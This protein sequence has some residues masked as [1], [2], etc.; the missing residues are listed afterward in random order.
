[1]FFSKFFLCL[2]RVHPSLCLIS[3]NRTNVKKF[4]RVPFFRFFGTMRLKISHVFFRK[5]FIKD[6]KESLFNFLKFCNRMDVKKSRRVP[7]FTVSGMVTWS[8]TL[9]PIF[10][11]LEGRCFFYATLKMCFTEAPPQFLPET[12]RFARVKDSSRF[13]ALCDLPKTIKNIFE[14]FRIFFSIFCFLKVF[15]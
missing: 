3:C 4:R 2:Q 9:Y 7:S 8:G 6:S 10:V 1:M 13:S 14:K 15:R 12:K 11:V 5:L